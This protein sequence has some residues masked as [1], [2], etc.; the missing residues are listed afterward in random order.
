MKKI[1]LI[2]FLAL[3]FSC[4]DHKD[5]PDDTKLVKPDSSQVKVDSLD[6]KEVPKQ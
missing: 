4:N 1:I 5:P 6:K 2:A 3:A